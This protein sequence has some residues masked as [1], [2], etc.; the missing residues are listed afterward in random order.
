MANIL[1]QITNGQMIFAVVDG[2][3]SAAGGTDLPQNS[4]A[5]YGGNW[6]KKNSS[7]ATDWSIIP[8]AESIR[9]TIGSALTEGS[10]IDIVVD[11]G[12]D[13]ITI[14]IEG[15]TIGT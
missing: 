5:A 9:D 6:W 11:D 13:T 8:D 3:P 7:T 15:L 2:D 10:G 14:S 12:G 1:D 4:F